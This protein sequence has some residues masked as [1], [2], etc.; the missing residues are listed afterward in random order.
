MDDKITAVLQAY[1]EKI[2]EER[3]NRHKARPGGEDGGQHRFMAVGPDTGQFINILA[4]GLEAPT[5]L[6]IGT[7]F[8]YS[9]IWLAD[10]ARASGGH[11]ITMERY[12]HKS[13][14]AKEMARKAGLADW[15][16][17]RVGDAV[18]MIPALSGKVDFVLLDLWKDLYVPCLKAFYPKLNSG[19]II[20]ADNMLGRAAPGA[21]AYAQAVRAKPGITS[22]V[23]PVGS[24]IEISRY[25]PV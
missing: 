25:E 2:S 6:E 5:I 13:A 19:A 8:G 22:V 14:Y 23:L 7:S 1:H 21:I 20:I 9:G 10:A 12:E 3:E 4:R 11:V 24:G 15:I 18:E 16:D 17:F